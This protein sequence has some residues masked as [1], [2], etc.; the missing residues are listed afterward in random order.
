[1]DVSARLLRFR[2]LPVTR[3]VLECAAPL[4]AAS[5]LR[6]WIPEINSNNATVA[7]LWTVAITLSVGLALHAMDRSYTAL[8]SANQAC[9]PVKTAS[10]FGRKL[11]LRVTVPLAGI[12]AIAAATIL[13]RGVA[14][15][16]PKDII[17]KLAAPGDML[18]QHPVRIGAVRGRQG[19]CYRYAATKGPVAATN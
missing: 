12:L 5:L 14:P 18:F 11:A 8:R 1:M 9:G 2:F 19:R 17:D 16:G 15:R 3:G 7:T 13:A 4:V 6:T 10:L